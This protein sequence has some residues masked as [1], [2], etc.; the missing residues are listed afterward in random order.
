MDHPDEDR[1]VMAGRH[2]QGLQCMSLRGDALPCWAAGTPTAPP[3]SG[4]LGLLLHSLSYWVSVNFFI[5]FISIQI[6]A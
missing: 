1:E 6:L 5:G 3:Q 2:P 4:P